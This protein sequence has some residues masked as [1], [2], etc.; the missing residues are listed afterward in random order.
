MEET[1]GQN[2]EEEAW[3][4]VIRGICSVR[5]S[6]NSSV[7]CNMISIPAGTSTDTASHK[8]NKADS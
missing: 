8:G 2:L 3:D 7:F 6:L 1:C 5:Q 4:Q